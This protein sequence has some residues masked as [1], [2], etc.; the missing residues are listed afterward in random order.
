[1]LSTDMSFSLARK[2]ATLPLKPSLS[3]PSLTRASS[4][5]AGRGWA[6]VDGHEERTRGRERGRERDFRVEEV[7]Y[8]Q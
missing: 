5:L 7:N 4:V 8:S 2:L 6:Y 3:A 1:M